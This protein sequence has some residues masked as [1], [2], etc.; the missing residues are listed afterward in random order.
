MRKTDTK[1]CH[2]FRSD[3][4][5]K[6]DNQWYFSTREDMSFGPYNKLSEAHAEL[7]QFLS[8]KNFVENSVNKIASNDY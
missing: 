3:R 7:V 4:F 6:V 8:F 1:A 2:F 5:F